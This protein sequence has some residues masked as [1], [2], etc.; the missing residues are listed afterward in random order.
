MVCRQRCLLP[1]ISALLAAGGCAD[2]AC[3]SEPPAMQVILELAPS[4]STAAIQT[5]RAEVSAAGQAKTADLATSPLKSGRRATF[6]VLVGDSGAGGFQAQI[7]VKALDAG[8]AVVARG[9]ETFS[10]SGDGC[11]AFSLRLSDGGDGGLPDG[12]PIVLDQGPKEGSPA[13]GPGSCTGC[14]QIGGICAAGTADSLCGKGGVACTDCTKVGSVC[15]TSAC[16]GVTY[17]WKTTSF[18]TCSAACFG[19]Q[20]RTVWCERSDGTKVSDSL[21]GGAKPAS[22]QS[23]NTSCTYSWKSGSWGTCS[24]KCDSGTQTRSVWCERSD[25]TKASDSLCS[26]AKPV[27]S[28]SC[29]TQACCTT[30]TLAGGQRCGGSTK[31]Q[32]TT[33]GSNTGSTSDRASCAVKCIS[34][35]TAISYTQWC[36]QLYEDSSSGTNWVCRLYDGYSMTASS[37]QWYGGLGRCTSP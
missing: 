37:G 15:Q 20:T 11:N 18:G 13:C 25:L 12:P 17:S 4:V 21:C 6:V 8:G 32:A 3:E 19:T 33:W 14:C 28:Q 23:C 24:K 7:S 30:D 22:S 36:C 34:W 27:T 10:A 2:R 31:A 5:L 16:V 29:N 9:D 1:V 26:G 35:A